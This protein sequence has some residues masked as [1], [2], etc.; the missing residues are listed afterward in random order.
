MPNG[1]MERITKAYRGIIPQHEH[2]IIVECA[3]VAQFGDY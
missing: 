2:G 1:P 3:G